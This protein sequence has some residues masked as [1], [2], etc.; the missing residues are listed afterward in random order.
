MNSQRDIQKQIIVLGGGLVGS[1]I[2]QDL[3]ADSVFSVT[4]ADRA[5]E[6]LEFLAAQGIATVER[7]L[8]E[9]ATI[10]D[11]VEPFDLVVGAV[12]GFMGFAMLG[13]VIEAEKDIVDISFFPE[14]PFRLDA[15]AKQR[16]VTAIVDCGLAPGLGNILMGRH[17]TM[18]DKV[19]TFLCYVGGL[20]VVRRKPYEYAV[21]FSPVDVIEEYTRPARY[22]EGGILVTKP[23]LS[24]VELLD[25]EGVGT[26]E[27]FNSDGLRTLAKTMSAPNMKEK[28]MRYPG[29]ADLIRIFRDT[30]FFSQEEI[31]VRGKPVRPLDVT[32]KLLFPAWKRKQGEEDMSIMRVII[33]GKD[34]GKHVRHT[35]DLIDRYDKVKDVTSMARTTGYTCAG[36][37]RLV[38]SGMFTRK[39]ICPPEYIGVEARAFDSLLAGLAERGIAFHSTHEEKT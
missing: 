29:H 15:L 37:V 2:A 31:E 14:D 11:L 16:N 21:V 20:P 19:D 27:A 26:L 13:A 10:R 1:A 30:G 36:V 5:S 3:A 18:M 35:Y 28:T 38:A 33:V 6:P 32:T 12:P 39:G 34:K 24:D 17:D 4:V 25:F 22:M 9:S 7:D 23:A 8:S